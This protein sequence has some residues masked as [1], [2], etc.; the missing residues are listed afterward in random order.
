[1]IDTGTRASFSLVGAI[2]E[3]AGKIVTVAVFEPVKQTLSAAGRLIKFFLDRG[4]PRPAAYAIAGHI[5]AES[6]FRTHDVGDG[7]RARY[8]AQWH[9]DR[10][11]GL[12]RLAAKKGTTPYDYETNLEYIDHELRTSET[13]AWRELHRARNLDDAVAA[14][15]HY[16]RPR[17]YSA[18]R[19]RRIHDWNT[20]LNFAR[21]YAKDY[22][23]LN[24]VI[25]G[26]L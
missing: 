22:G 14:F 26:G 25:V 5:R 7:G 4:Y 21:K 12:K 1:M 10:Q 11:R 3:G 20:R 19:P 9:P 24:P 8:L 6:N 23:H 18:A 2:F 17:G 16:E 15:A 13:L